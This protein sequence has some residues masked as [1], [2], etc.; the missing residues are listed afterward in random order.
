MIW[1]AVKGLT[2]SSALLPVLPPEEVNKKNIPGVLGN[3]V[4]LLQLQH[5]YSKCVWR[6]SCS[7]GS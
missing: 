3:G 7:S 5:D 6:G 4:F 2:G 1:L